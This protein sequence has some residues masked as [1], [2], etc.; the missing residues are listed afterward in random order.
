MTD[1]EAY[2]LAE[3]LCATLCAENPNLK[4]VTNA[5]EI[6]IIDPIALRTIYLYKCPIGTWS[7][8]VFSSEAVVRKFLG[9]NDSVPEI[10][11]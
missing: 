1:T 10:V 6:T 4:S 3:S 7:H 11:S 8:F 5:F 2:H 9:M